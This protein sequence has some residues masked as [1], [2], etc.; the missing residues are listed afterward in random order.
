MPARI[1]YNGKNPDNTTLLSPLIVILKKRNALRY[2]ANEIEPII[3]ALSCVPNIDEMYLKSEY[4]E[5]NN[6]GVFGK[7]SGLLFSAEERRHTHSGE[8]VLVAIGGLI[9]REYCGGKYRSGRKPVAHRA[10][11]TGHLLCEIC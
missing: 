2:G 1:T 8:R 5:E 10:P 4:W 11:E 7:R 6:S 3:K 9:E